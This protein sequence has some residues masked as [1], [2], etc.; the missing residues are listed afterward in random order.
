MR[1][2]KTGVGVEIS[3]ELTDKIYRAKTE[4][5]LFEFSEAYDEYDTQSWTVGDF[6][7]SYFSN[8]G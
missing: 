5:K 7:L 2:D 6:Y 4:V 1:L 8:M 3:Y